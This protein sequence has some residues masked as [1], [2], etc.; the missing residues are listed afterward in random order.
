MDV[1]CYWQQKRE[2]YRFW[3]PILAALTGARI[4]ELTDL[5]KT[6]IHQVLEGT[7]YINL[8]EEFDPETGKKLRHLKTKSS[9]RTN[10]IHSKLIEIGFLDYIKSIKDGLIFPIQ[11]SRKPNISDPGNCSKKM[12]ALLKKFKVYQPD[13]KVFHSFRHSFISD[14]YR[15]NVDIKVFSSI[16]GHLSKD[17]AKVAPE[18]INIQ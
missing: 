10:P 3:L 2:S 11:N 1:L 14:L 9:I 7:H 12:S 18:L 15:Q 8:D 5:K 13:I 6:D 17:E 16:T 4:G